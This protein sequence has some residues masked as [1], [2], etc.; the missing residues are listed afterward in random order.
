MSG[1]VSENVAPTPSVQAQ[2]PVS[3][4]DSGS[5]LVVT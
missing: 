5:T 2:L 1:I 3:T 4:I